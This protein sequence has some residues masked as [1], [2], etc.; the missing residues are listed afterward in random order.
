MWGKI[1]YFMRKCY[2]L[3]D[4]QWKREFFPKKNNLKIVHSGKIFCIDIETI[5]WIFRIQIVVWIKL[6]KTAIHKY[7][8]ISLIHTILYMNE[9]N[10]LLTYLKVILNTN[11]H[12]PNTMPTTHTLLLTDISFQKLQKKKKK[13]HKTENDKHKQEVE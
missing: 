13:Q 10:T 5:W 1:E 12:K 11:H 9:I 3:F 7:N 8:I 4:V 6:L 2:K